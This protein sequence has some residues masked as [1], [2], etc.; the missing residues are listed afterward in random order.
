MFNQVGDCQASLPGNLL[1]MWSAELLGLA[2]IPAN[3]WYYFQTANKRYIGLLIALMSLMAQ[4]HN[5]QI[6][7]QWIC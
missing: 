1:E 2:L 6:I 5:Y 3:H 4:G 7:H